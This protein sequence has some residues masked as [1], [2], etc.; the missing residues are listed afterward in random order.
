[1][2]DVVYTGQTGIAQAQPTD[3]Q[4][5]PTPNWDTATGMAYASNLPEVGTIIDDDANPLDAEIELHRPHQEG[6]PDLQFT[7]AFD[8]DPDPGDDQTR[9]I[10]LQS[11]TFRVLEPPPGEATGG[12][13]EIVWTQVEPPVG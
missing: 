2:A 13:F 7:C 6:E 5:R 4:G 11:Q 12:S 1:M 9:H 3:A 10:V 8:G